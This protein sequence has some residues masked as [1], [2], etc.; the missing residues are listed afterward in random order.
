MKIDIYQS[1]KNSKKFLSVKSGQ[2]VAAINVPDLDYQS[3]SPSKLGVEINP[4]QPLVGLDIKEAI[5]AIETQGYYLHG[6]SISF[7]EI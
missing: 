4:D 2:A 1:T 5:T 3:V 7:S 6:V